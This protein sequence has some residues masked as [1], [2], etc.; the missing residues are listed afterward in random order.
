MTRG[1]H[2]DAPFEAGRCTRQLGGVETTESTRDSRF[3]GLTWMSSTS[4][5]R[6]TKDKLRISQ[7]SG[8]RRP[9]GRLRITCVLFAQVWNSDFRELKF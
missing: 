5:E 3:V 8:Y 6:G 4:D 7:K 2:Y 9:T 1:G